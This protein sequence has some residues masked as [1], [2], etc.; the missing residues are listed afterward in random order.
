V[1]RVVIVSDLH[2]GHRAGLTCP[3]WMT[4]ESAPGVLGTFAKQQRAMWAWYSATMA[5]LQPIDILIV[6]GDAM[7]G[8]GGRNKGVELITAD[9]MAQCQIA[10]ACIK[11]AKAKGVFLV[12]GTPYH[13]SP[14]GENWDEVLEQLVGADAL[15]GHLFLQVEGVIFDVKHKVGSSSTPYGRH[16][17]IAKERVWNV[18]WNERNGAPLAN[19]IVRSHVHYH[20]FNGNPKHLSMTTPALQ[21]M[22]SKFGV[23]QCSGIVDYGLVHFDVDGNKYGWQSHLLESKHDILRR[24]EK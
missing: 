5:S 11:E 22:G 19:V 7:D 10:A 12:T 13:T 23:E 6:N 21:G 16:T 17:A 1:T 3:G 9:M 18:M 24:Y 20:E 15:D 14:D 4:P 8:K 2:A